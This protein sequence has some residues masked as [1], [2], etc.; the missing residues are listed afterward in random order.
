MPV[1][2]GSHVLGALLLTLVTTCTAS[3]QTEGTVAV[4]LAVSS[5]SA[6]ESGAG[7]G[8][9][10]GFTWRIGHDRTGWGWHYGLGWYTTDLEQPIASRPTRFGALRIRPVVAG[11]G[12]TQVIG[13]TSISAKVMGGYAINSF[14]LHPGFDDRYRAQLGARTVT[15]DVSNAFVLKPE[16]SAWIDISRKIGLQLSAGYTVARP[17]VTVSSTLGNDRRHIRA[18]VVTLKIGAAYAVF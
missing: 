10:V 6:T 16:I 14:D 17:E 12:Y 13:R 3:A 2:R 4:G 18:D 8:A 9:G 15:T 1:V 7:G 5:R 11:Y